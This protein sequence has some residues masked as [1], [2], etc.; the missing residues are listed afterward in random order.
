M[1]T[2]HTSNDGKKLFMYI[3]LRPYDLMTLK[4]K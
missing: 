3:G 2:F 4:D 1:H